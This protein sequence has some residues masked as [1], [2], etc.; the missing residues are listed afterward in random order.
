MRPLH[1]LSLLLLLPACGDSGSAANPDAAPRPDA[2]A[3]VT[4]GAGSPACQGHPA[5]AQP[6]DIGPNL[7]DE[8]GDP[9]VARLTPPSYPFQVTSVSYKLTGM[10]ATCGTNIAHA[11]TVFAAPSADQPPATPANAQRIAVDASATDQRTLVVTKPLPTPIT[12]TQGEDLYVAVEMDANAAK[13]VAVC[14]DGCGISADDKRQFWSEQK[15]APFTWATLY[16]FGI[17]EDYAIW[18]EG[19]PQ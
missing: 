15:Q 8:I 14:L 16:S 6:A 13:T 19:Q 3:I 4:F 1:A 9:A 12:L 5:S 7:P 11:V 2:A 18:A 10:E 17:A